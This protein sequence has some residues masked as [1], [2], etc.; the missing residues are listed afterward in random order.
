M[1]AKRFSGPLRRLIRAEVSHRRP[2]GAYSLELQLECG[3]RKKVKGSQEPRERARCPECARSWA[4]NG[5]QGE[6]SGCKE[7]G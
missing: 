4:P 6:A 3:H 5:H 2:D 7:R 1:R